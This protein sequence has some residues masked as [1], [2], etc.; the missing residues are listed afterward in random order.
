MSKPRRGVKPLRIDIALGG[1]MAVPDRHP[2]ILDSLLLA[3][4]DVRLDLP[5]SPQSLPLQVA[6]GPA[7]PAQA[8][9]FCWLASALEIDWLGPSSDRVL[10]RNAR[11]LELFD[12]RDSHGGSSV[13]LDRGLTK[14]A[15]KRIAVRQAN[16]ARC[17]C[18]G[19]AVEIEA[20]L[21]RLDALG[22]HRHLGLG[23]VQGFSVAEDAEAVEKSWLRPTPWQLHELDP[24]T[25]HRFRAAGRATPPYWDRDLSQQ[26]WW[27]SL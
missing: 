25:G 26:A 21:A 2:L 20:I 13:D 22:A 8:T 18:L 24:Y 11:P 1:H 15:R 14:V 16:F 27:P 6:Y 23:L 7:G 12:D 10:H 9:E 19:V 17:W 3:L 5:F 4:Q